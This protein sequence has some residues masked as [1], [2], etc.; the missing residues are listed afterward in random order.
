MEKTVRYKKK[1]TEPLI[2]PYNV[3]NKLINEID[4]K[5]MMNRFGIKIESTDIELYRNSLTH[6]SF[7][8]KEFYDKNME[9]IKRHKQKMGNV[10][11]LQD[12]SNERLEFLGD[13]IIK[14]VIAEYLF[15]RYPKKD[16]GFMTKLK[17]LGTLGKNI[18]TG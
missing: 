9:E 2:I 13:T 6:K 5:E 18:G 12:E 1:L 8:K 17:I 3:N 14:A 11:E 15:E 4:L 7:I 10:L 16:E